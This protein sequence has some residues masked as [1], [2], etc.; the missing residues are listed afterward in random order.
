MSYPVLLRL[1][2]DLKIVKDFRQNI[3]KVLLLSLLKTEDNVVSNWG[4]FGGKNGE[5]IRIAHSIMCLNDSNEHFGDCVQQCCSCE[6]C[7]TL[8][9]IEETTEAIISTEKV[10]PNMEQ[11]D[12]LLLLIK[13]ILSTQPKA[14]FATC[15][16][17]HDYLKDESFLKFSEKCNKIHNHETDTLKRIENFE[18]EPKELEDKVSELLAYTESCL[19]QEQYVFE[20]WWSSPVKDVFPF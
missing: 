3:P 17:Y 14:A 5:K 11:K 12:R 10:W 13:V 18:K 8:N 15:Q 20:E 9:H 4:D 7:H 2:E 1:P 6:L 16:E 19:K